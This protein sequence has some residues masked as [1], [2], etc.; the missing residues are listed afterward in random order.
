MISTRY[1]RECGIEGRTEERK[2]K[3]SKNRAKSLRRGK[4]KKMA[5][6][7]CFRNHRKACRMGLVS[8]EKL[9]HTGLVE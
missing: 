6:C 8:V 5:A 7:W 2:G 1:E 9:E 3:Y 4:G